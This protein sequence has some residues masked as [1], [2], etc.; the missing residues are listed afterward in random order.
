MGDKRTRK[1]S[2]KISPPV[3]ETP[4]SGQ[5]LP[6]LLPRIAP[7]SIS[8]NL[9]TWSHQRAVQHEYHRQERVRSKQNNY[10]SKKI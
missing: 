7:V 6:T 1:K 2:E 10:R 3:V 5:E 4:D 8:D 9:P